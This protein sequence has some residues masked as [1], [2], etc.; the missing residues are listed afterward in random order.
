MPLSLND[1][2]TWIKVFKT[3]MITMILTYSFTDAT[4]FT[5]LKCP[6]HA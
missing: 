6:L 4:R 1:M 2:M 3:D 5:L